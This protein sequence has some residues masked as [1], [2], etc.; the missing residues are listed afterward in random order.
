[1]DDRLELR[2]IDDEGNVGRSIGGVRK[3]SGELTYHGSR[4]VRDVLES[5][6]TRRGCPATEAFDLL[7][8]DPWCNSKLV[9]QAATGVFANVERSRQTLAR[10]VSILESDSNGDES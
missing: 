3:E 4:V 5:L 9:L 10:N 6:A 1:M 7:Y 2:V 8:A